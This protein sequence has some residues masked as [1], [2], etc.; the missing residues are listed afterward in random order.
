MKLKHV[1]KKKPR[2][3]IFTFWEFVFLGKFNKNTIFFGV[4]A[5]FFSVLEPKKTVANRD[6]LGMIL[7][8]PGDLVRDLC[9]KPME[10]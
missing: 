2:T 8:Y 9:H 4:S 7:D 5:F 1:Q 10:K 6:F 3:E